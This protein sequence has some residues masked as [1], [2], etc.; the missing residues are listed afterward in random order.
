[1]NNILLAEWQASPR[2][3]TSAIVIPDGCRDL[4]MC[5]APGEKPQ[6]FVSSLE[7]S[8]YTVPIKADVAMQGFRLL[9]GARIDEELLLMSVQNMPV[10]I[11][12]VSCRLDSYSYVSS[13]VTEILT[14]LAVSTNSVASAAHELGVSS[15]SMQRLL[16]RETGHSPAFWLQLARVRKAARAVLETSPLAEIA[17]IYG[18]SDQAHMT[19]EFKRWLNISPARVRFS[20]E[21]VEQLNQPGYAS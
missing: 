1:M 13:S 7:E 8:T 6:W 20:S 17:A 3:D 10:D 21:I 18:Y 5:H 4:I 2:D 16:K 12:E 14:C 9:P 11:D 19:R 15:R